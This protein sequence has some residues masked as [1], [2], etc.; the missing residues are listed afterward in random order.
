[1]TVGGGGGAQSYCK[2]SWCA[3]NVAKMNKQPI[4]ESW[5]GVFN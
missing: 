4:Q 5:Y 1:M 2:T 3:M